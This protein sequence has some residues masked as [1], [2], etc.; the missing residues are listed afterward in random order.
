MRIA[1]AALVGAVAGAA[2]LSVA[3]P[4]GA[5]SSGSVDTTLEQQIQK[6]LD[7]VKGSER[8]SVNTVRLAEGVSVTFPVKDRQ[9]AKAATNGVAPRVDDWFGCSVG[10]LCMWEHIEMSGARINFTN[11][12]T[13]NLWAY[14]WGNRV[15]SYSNNQTGNVYTLFYDSGSAV[16]GEEA[17]G[18]R[19]N[20]VDNGMND[21]FDSVKVC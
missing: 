7:T 9:A 16:W 13:E 5:Q 8:I 6:T 19:R 1:K 21:R 11:C 17:T 12:R 14:G 3:V 15:S 4:A 20:L 2:L 10:Y 18:Y